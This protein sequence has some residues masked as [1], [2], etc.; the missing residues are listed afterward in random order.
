M[1]L[2]DILADVQKSLWADAEKVEKSL[3][4]AKAKRLKN[5][6]DNTDTVGWGKELIPTNNL[7]SSILTIPWHEPSFIKALPWFHGFN[8]GISMK[9]PIK[10]ELP[11]ARAN[12]E[13]KTGAWLISE[14][15]RVATGDVTITQQPFVVQIDLSD[16][17]VN[18]SIDDLMSYVTSEIAKSVD[19]DTEYVILNADSR[20]ENTGNINCSDAKPSTTFTDGANDIRLQFSD[21]IR[22][23]MLTNSLT[24]SVWTLEWYHFIAVRQ[25]L[26]RYATKLSDLMLLMDSVA[27]HKALTL[28]EFKRANENGRKSTVDTGAISNIA[29][30]D[31]YLPASFPATLADGTVS[32]I[33]ENNTKWGFIYLYKPAVQFGFGKDLEI[34]VARIPWKWYSIIWTYEFGFAI[35]NKKAWETDNRIYGGINVNEL[36]TSGS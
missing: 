8:M 22:K 1:N 4:D 13:W 6:T 23:H 15:N 5:A 3:E 18:Y 32:K 12:S 11:R 30:V 7:L 35:V 17:F 9:L 28:N 21:S 20:D 19:A 26:G 25:K 31:M 27:Y 33:P 29:G 24:L 16:R 14:G 36:T 34:E 10:W 2:L